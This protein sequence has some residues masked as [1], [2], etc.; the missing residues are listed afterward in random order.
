MQCAGASNEKEQSTSVRL[1]QI[2]ALKEFVDDCI[3]DKGP[4]DVV[5]V[6]GDFNV[7]ANHEDTFEYEMMLNILRGK[8]TNSNDRAKSTTSHHKIISFDPMQF[9]VKDMLVDR[10]GTHP[11][12]YGDVDASGQ[13]VESVLTTQERLGCRESV[14]YTFLLR[15]SEDVGDGG[16]VIDHKSTRV[17][18]F[19]VEGEEFS[20]LSGKGRRLA[21]H[22]DWWSSMHTRV[23]VCMYNRRRRGWMG[24][25]T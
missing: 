7:N 25:T 2:C 20:H 5:L 22:D 11:I 10:Y 17:E 21:G 13:P 3:F 6:M 16:I 12:T 1:S 15:G 14:D 23:W 18:K 4:R 8:V 19:Q 24:L 9:E